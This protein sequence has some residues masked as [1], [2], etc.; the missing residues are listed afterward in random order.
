M[1]QLIA[2]I[3]MLGLSLNMNGQALKPQIGQWQGILDYDEEKVPFTF[4]FSLNN[5]GPVIHLING[6]ERIELN[7][8]KI[9]GDSIFILL[10][11]FDAE[12]RAKFNTH[13]MDGYWKKGYRKGKTL[14]RGTYGAPRYTPSKRA[15]LKSLKKIAITFKPEN[16]VPYTG[17][18]QFELYQ[19]KVTGTILTEVGDFRYFEG[20]M[21]KDSLWA[22]AFD[23]VH[24]FLLK[25]V[26]NEEGHWSGVLYFERGYKEEW[27]GKFDETASLKNPFQKIEA[28]QRPYFDILLAGDKNQRL[29][30]DDFFNKV[31]IVQLFGTWCP[32]SY[33]QTNFLTDWYSNRT[34][35]DVEL[36]AVSYELNFSQEYAHKRIEDYKNDMSI[37]YKVMLGGRMNKGEAALAFPFM[38]KLNAFPTLVILDRNGF[39]RYTFN[40][41]NGPATGHYYNEFKKQLDE[42]VAELLA[43]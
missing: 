18:G 31:L 11:P 34:T 25:A 1:N 12:I 42:I 39:A 6:E 3:F 20:V 8:I 17:I 2:I 41:F 29:N 7:K 24:G 36:L 19:N 33:D 13:E 38:D 27:E 5:D 26:V 21:D 9:D 4:E 15:N 14:F 30:I 10:Q 32:N 35:T 28:G 16:A 43:E 23:G 37:P 22:S 40:Y